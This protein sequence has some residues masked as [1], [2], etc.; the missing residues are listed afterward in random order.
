[1]NTITSVFSTQ[2][3]YFDSNATKDISFRIKQLKKLKQVLQTNEQRLEE[4]IYHDFGKSAF[5]TYLTELS[6]VYAEINYY[7][8]NVKKLSKRKR[9]S[10]GLAN[11]PAKGY[12][13]PE[14]LGVTLVIG[15]W[16]YPYQLS[17][18]PALT[19]MAAGNTVIIK[20]SEL[21]MRTSQ[22]LAELI[23]ENFDKE[24]LYVVE[25]GID[26][27]TELLSLP[28]DKIFFTG[29][30]TVGKIIYEAAAKNLVPVTL[31]LGGKS[32]AIVLKDCDIPMTA[33]RLVWAK[34]LNAGQTCV[35]PDYI[36]VEAS[37]KE[38]L[39][40]Y[41]KIEM[42]NY[43]QQADNLPTHYLQI[44]NTKNFDRLVSLIDTTKVCYGGNTDRDKR[45]ISPTILDEVVWEDAIMQEE[46]FGP[47][48]PILTFKSLDEV[49]SQIK[50]RPKPLACYVY[51]KDKVLIDKIL[52]E[53]SFGGGAVNDSLMHLSTNTLP[54]GGVGASGI[55]NYHGKYGF[56]TFSHYKSILHKPFWFESSIKYPPY[57]KQKE[58]W[59]RKLFK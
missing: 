26:E 35:A 27:T 53:V 44:I 58:G 29:S 17:L 31:E 39:I 40:K 13:I 23:N 34:L 2:K 59:L 8:K 6:I 19:A 50:K 1:M 22:V 3:S 5:E 20:P 49:I 56:E 15:A 4:A 14:P 41:L 43:P 45:F 12:I 46:I 21:P 52:K 24:Y 33:K 47:L 30:T 9:V 32:P 36:V 11:F 37:I 16:N 28:F 7:I 55:G 51:G 25:G 54:F 38:E 42:D 48:L 18:L 57:T 10:V